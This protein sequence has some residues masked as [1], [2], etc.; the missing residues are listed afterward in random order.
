LTLFLSGRKQSE[1]WNAEQGSV[2]FFH[3]K[4]F[5]ENILNR[6]GIKTEQISE[7]SSE[8]FSSALRYESR[9]KLLVEFGFVKKTFLKKFD[10]K[11]E[12][13]YADF[14]WNNL[15]VL[16]KNSSVK[17][18]E[19]PKF[20]EVRR[21]LALIV[22]KNV[23]YDLL[24]SLAF[25]AEKNILKEVNLFDVYEGEKITAGKKSYA[26]S[27]TLL[28]EKATLTDKQVEAVMEKFVKIYK[29]KA[30]AEIRS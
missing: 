30:G 1:S 26:L 4:S 29:E 19:V 21:D 3:L 8:I 13:Y 6:I 7:M 24:R 12:V 17:F 22:D 9:K 23:K 2:D 20:P 11:Q 28:D 18:K 14:N 16:S 27:F 15:E 25:N 5:V 10:I